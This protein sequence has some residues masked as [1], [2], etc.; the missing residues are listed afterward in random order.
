MSQIRKS[1]IDAI[2]TFRF[3]AAICLVLH[4][5]FPVYFPNSVLLSNFVLQTG[6]TFFFVLSG[7]ILYY[8]Y[9]VL[10]SKKD[11]LN[12][13]VA[14][15]AR[16][17]PLHAFMLL[18]SLLIFSN[19]EFTFLQKITP[20]FLLQ[21][22]IPKTAFCF[23][24]NSVSWT[25]S[26]EMFFYLTFP[27]LISNIKRNWVQKLVILSLPI[28]LSVLLIK[29]FHIP[30][31]E[32]VMYS[33]KITAISLLHYCPISRI[34]EFFIGILVGVLAFDN[35]TIFSKISS[36]SA[37]LLEF[38][39][40]TLSIFSS[41]IFI[42]T[43]KALNISSH[44]ELLNTF[45]FLRFE[46]VFFAAL[47]FV[48]SAN[49]GVFSKILSF[50]PFVTLGEISF[51]IYMIHYILL[52]S[53]KDYKLFL[54]N[55]NE[56]LQFTLYLSILLLSSYLSWKFFETPVRRY[57]VKKFSLNDNITISKHTDI[58]RKQLT[59]EYK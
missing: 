44:S 50:K 9:P 51:S 34:I 41:T 32:N 46:T 57:I 8:N 58:E 45:M 25:L 43:S 38:L 21:A 40:I 31:W 23:A 18:L 52:Y 35:K 39:T 20:A 13:F 36:K 48:F 55:N 49:K 47:L 19:N 11:K 3:F 30:L 54:I 7:F 27:F 1:K 42:Y 14:R 17:W 37:S 10:S 16:I 2:T 29:I 12:F 24:I 4:H 6:V 28:A 33:N 59:N 22:W 53:F 5:C 26:C 15:F 56:F